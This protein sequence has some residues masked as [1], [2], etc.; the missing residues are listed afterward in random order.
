MLSIEHDNIQ[1]EENGAGSITTQFHRN[2]YFAYISLH[3]S[4][5]NGHSSSAMSA[6]FLIPNYWL[7]ITRV[8]ADFRQATATHQIITS[9]KVTLFSSIS[10]FSEWS[11]FLTRTKG[12]D[13]KQQRRFYDA[14]TFEFK[15]PIWHF[16]FFL[17]S[18]LN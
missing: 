14:M 7:L 4:T 3:F 2:S 9:S 16:V 11:A 6:T 10:I 1:R 17:C 8:S 13:K 15:V 12:I 5:L 18:R